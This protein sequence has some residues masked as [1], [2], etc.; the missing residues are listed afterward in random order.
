MICLA[1]GLGVLGFAA[2]RHARRCHGGHHGWLHHRH[3]HHRHAHRGWLLHA[4][5]ARIDAS[6]AQE[7][8]IL[9]TVDKLHEHVHTARRSLLAVRGDLGAAIRG[10]LLDDAALGAVLGRVDASASEVR[11]A[12]IEALRAIH[13][14]LDDDQRAQ[15]ADLLGNDGQ[16]WWRRGPYR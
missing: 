16:G 5:L 8:V 6:P 2:M 10:P 1:I 11:T 3:A 4:A 7:R 12:A 9:R 15:V 14:I 13:A